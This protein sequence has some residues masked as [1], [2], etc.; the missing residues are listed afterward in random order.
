MPDLYSDYGPCPD[1]LEGD[2]DLAMKANPWNVRRILRKRGGPQGRDYFIIAEYIMGLSDVLSVEYIADLAW[3]AQ[4][5]PDTDVPPFGDIDAMNEW[6]GAEAARTALRKT[7]RK[8][9]K[10]DFAARNN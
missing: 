7:A 6:S 1:P 4:K 3:Q 8:I 9:L 2:P 5:Y 10:I